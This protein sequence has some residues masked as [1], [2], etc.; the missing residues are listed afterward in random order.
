MAI[1]RNLVVLAGLI[2]IEQVKGFGGLV[3]VTLGKLD[4]A[5]SK[6]TL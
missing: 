4:L 5:R 3:H 2:T 1:R 6:S